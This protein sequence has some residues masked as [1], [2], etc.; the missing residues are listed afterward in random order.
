MP[1]CQTTSRAAACV[2]IGNFDGIRNS[3]PWKRA[4]RGRSRRVY[5]PFSGTNVNGCV[6]VT[7]N[8][9]PSRTGRQLTLR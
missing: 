6:P 3:M 9:A 2:A 4:V 7:L 8:I 5:S 1:R